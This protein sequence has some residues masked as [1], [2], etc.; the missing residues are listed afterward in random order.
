MVLSERSRDGPEPD[1]FDLLPVFLF[2]RAYRVKPRTTKSTNDSSGNVWLAAGLIVLTGII[3]Y[4]NSFDVPFVFDDA[5]SIL[6]N[7]SIRRLASLD[8]LRPP[9]GRPLPRT[10]SRHT[11]GSAS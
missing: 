7:P 2:R 3:A 4:R 8:A 6:E 10:T 5:L 11:P 1:A 9:S